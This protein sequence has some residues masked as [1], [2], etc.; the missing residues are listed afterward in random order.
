MRSFRQHCLHQGDKSVVV[1][2]LFPEVPGSI[3][4][5]GKTKENAVHLLSFNRRSYP[6]CDGDNLSPWQP[7]CIYYIF[8][9]ELATC[10]KRTRTKTSK[11]KKTL[12]SAITA[13]TF[14]SAR[15]RSRSLTSPPSKARETRLSRFGLGKVA[16]PRT[17][18][19]MAIM[20]LAPI[21]QSDTAGPVESHLTL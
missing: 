16:L 5:R 18:F 9:Q 21:T 2:S 8:T 17:A 13:R 19:F 14:A 10:S 7:L 1:M 11:L 6:L 20:V 15:W 12:L 4:E 3:P